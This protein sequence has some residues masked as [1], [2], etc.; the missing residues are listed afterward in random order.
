[1]KCGCLVCPWAGSIGRRYRQ[2][3]QQTC[4]EDLELSIPGGDD[5]EM[6]GKG[7]WDSDF[8]LSPAGDCRTVWPHSWRPGVMQSEVN[9]KVPADSCWVW[10][11]W[12]CTSVLN[13]SAWSEFSSQLLSISTSCCTVHLDSITQQIS[14]LLLLYEYCWAG[15]CFQWLQNGDCLGTSV[16]GILQE[17][18]Q[19]LFCRDDC[20][21]FLEVCVE[22]HICFLPGF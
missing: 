5:N 14:T 6:R 10:Q 17:T 19:L 3:C 7:L 11:P 15:T 1:M 8:F 22:Q 4:K 13:P 20:S 2:Q 12:L 18:L 9:E 16:K 21:N